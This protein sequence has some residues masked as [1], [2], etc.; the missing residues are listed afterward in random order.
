MT[1]PKAPPVVDIDRK[2]VEEMLERAKAALDPSDFELIK[3]L[4]DGYAQLM[5]LVLKRGTTIARLRRLFGLS[6]SEKLA[7]V[8]G[9]AEHRSPTSGTA[10]QGDAAAAAEA[11][12]A[13]TAHDDATDE[14]ATQGSGEGAAPSKSVDA[15]EDESKKKRKKVKGH[16]RVPASAY[17]MARHIAVLHASL[18]AGDPCPKNGCKGK[19]Y[20]LA[21]PATILRIFGQPPLTAICW[22]CEQLALQHLR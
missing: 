2:A 10:E 17:L 20:R 14:G 12:G 18:R 1:R 7:N 21:E 11:S 16:G 5:A 6:G 9:E 13:D 19:V 4:V 15:A 8:V 22:N 3:G